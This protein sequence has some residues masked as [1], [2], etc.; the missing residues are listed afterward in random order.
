MRILEFQGSTN[1][2]AAAAYAT[3]YLFGLFACVLLIGTYG[4][5]L[6]YIDGMSEAE[7]GLRTAPYSISALVAGILWLVAAVVPAFVR[8]LHDIGLSG[9]WLA[10]MA[11]AL[12]PLLLLLCWRGS[13]LDNR[14]GAKPASSYAP[15]YVIIASVILTIGAPL[16]IMR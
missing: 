16:A 2:V 7:I 6:V 14:F 5:R 12:L 9:W 3:S 11:P 8:R 4:A 15:I 1:R 13:E 10:I